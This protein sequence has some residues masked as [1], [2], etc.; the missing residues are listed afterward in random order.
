METAWE[1][2]E[3]AGIDP[4]SLRG[5]RTGVFTGVM[6]GD[7]AARLTA[8]P[9]EFEG[10]LLAGNTSS[11]VSGRLAYAYGLEGPAITVDT[12]CSS[13]LVSLHLAAQALRQGECDLAL[14]GGVT[15]MAAPSTFIE[16]SRQRGLAP[17]GRCKSFSTDADGTGWSE[18]VGLLLVE[19]ASDALARGH[20]ILA[21]LRGSAVNS[22]GASNGLTA[23]NGPSQDRVIRQALAAAGLRTSDVD[24]VEAHGTGTTLGDPIEA[25]ALLATY[26]QDRPAGQPLWLGSLKSN[27]GH[28]QAAAG[29]GGVIKMI[30]AL[31]HGLLP[32]TLHVDQPSTHVDWESGSVALLT[33]AQPWPAGERPRRAGVSSFGISGTNAHVILEEPPHQTPPNPTAPPGTSTPEQSTPEQSAGQGSATAGQQAVTAGQQAASAGAMLPLVLSGADERGLRAQADRLRQFVADRPELDLA[34]LGFSLATSRARLEHRAAVLGAD[35]AALL[36][37]L[38]ALARGE[39]AAGVITGTGAGRG[40][41]AFL[42]T[43]QGSQRVGMGRDL[44]QHD[45]VFA[46]ALDEVCAHLDGVLDRPLKTVLFA[47]EGSADSAILDQTAFTQAAVF[48]IEVALYRLAERAGLVPDYLLGHSV[49]EVAAAHVAGVLDLPDAC[50]LIAARGRAM[51]SARDNGAMAAIQASE[52]EVRESLTG[53]EAAVAIA[54]LNGPSATVI[55]GDDVAV[56]SIAA[57]WAA[58]GRRTARLPVSHA[59]HSPHMDDVL[60]AFRGILVE[61]TFHP[62]RRPIVSDVTGEL[63][64]AEQLCSPD[65]WLQHVRQPVRFLDGMRQL[66]TLGVTE[67]VELGPDGVLSAMARACLTGEPGMLAPMLRAGRP[68]TASVLA[69]LAASHVRGANLDWSLIFPGARRVPLP[70]YAFRRNRYWLDAPRGIGTAAAFGLGETGH[71]LLGATT[72]L[73]DGETTVLTGR[74]SPGTDH[75]LREHRV[76]DLDLLP[77]TAFLELALRAGEQVGCPRVAELTVTAPLRLPQRGAVALQVTVRAPDAAGLRPVT[78]HARP[79]DDESPWTRYASGALSPEPGSAERLAIWP[80]PRA[81]EVDLDGSYDRLAEHG[82]R[83]GPAF[84]GLHRLWRHDD[85]LYAEITLPTES[86]ADAG[87]FA[88]HPAL[89]DAALHALLPT[90][91]PSDPDE[92][93]EVLLPFSWSGVTVHTPGASAA[94]VRLSV[95]TAEGGTQMASLVLTD[96]TGAALAT[97]DELLLRPLSADLPPADVRAD[98]DGLYAVEWVRPP[99]GGTPAEPP[100]WVVLDDGLA[101]VADG[102]AEPV[103]GLGERPAGP[104]VPGDGGNP[105]DGSG[106]YRDLAGLT[107]ALDGGVPVPRMVLMPVPSTTGPAAELPDRAHETLRRMLA[108]SQE[109][110]A[111]ER[112]VDTRLVVVTRGAVTAADTTAADLAQAGV[113]GLLRAAQTEHP[114]R[115]VLL[116]LDDDPRSGHTLAAALASGEPQVAVRGGEIRVPRLARTPHSVPRPEPEPVPVPDWAG[117]TVLITGATGTLGGLLARHLVVAH[118]V[119][120][121]LLLS[122]RGPAAPGADELRAELAGLGATATIVAC[123][124][125]DRSALAAVLAELPAQVRLSAVVH[126]AGVLDDGVLAALTP[127]QLARVLRPKVDAAWHLHELTREHP[128]SAFVLYSSVAGLLGTA[129]QGNYCAAN[130][131]LD[132]L[133]QH[134]QAHGLPATSLAWG[135]WAEASSITSHL[136]EVDRQRMARVGLLPLAVDEAMPL[137]DLA[138]TTGAPVVAV[139]RLDPTAL[140]GPVDAHPAPLRSLVRRPARPTGAGTAAAPA[141]PTLAQRL[142]DLTVAERRETLTDL[143]RARVAM[144]LGHA[145]PDDVDPTRAFQELGFDSLTAI[146]LRNQLSTATGLR[147]PATLVFDY[148]SPAALAGYLLDQIVVERPGA[149]LLAE[150]DTLATLVRSTALDPDERASVSA[151]LR[152]LLNLCGDTDAGESVDTEP[153]D[154]LAA[155][156]DEE[157]FALVD[158]LD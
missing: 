42:F 124:V 77:G 141:G 72:E 94:R 60:D 91:A 50:R 97:V 30:Q 90:S 125:A 38:D 34:D 26:G 138:V 14:A 65:Y 41:T 121:L 64:T 99:S 70:T 134:R 149:E 71:P 10:F 24:A 56:D 157:L 47:P 135:L 32:R 62:P 147:L 88:V 74:L 5:S 85:D 114:D 137:F 120:D 33:S 52:D 18:G 48:A 43:G 69:V 158:D 140:R 76:L 83:Y 22:D 25:Q 54:A 104:A 100:D 108:F 51:Q 7:Y 75:W 13:S 136:A 155:A 39:D 21:V 37:G 12:A 106:P 95:S 63:A 79:D 98:Q 45:A 102:L 96:H 145:D 131:F 16:F 150:L 113:W 81:A 15:V 9:P 128:L 89:L 82:Y 53:F 143:V 156:S 19:R 122:R 126:T 115:F 31:R 2:F 46:T 119:R 116:D 66:Q 144:V 27:I 112:L 86:R 20:Q 92:K 36:R 118:G 1:V 154:D 133:A 151:R 148:P 130:T 73:A 11:V 17:D 110:L 35:R 28:A 129:G 117:G 87:L 109:W 29:V 61:L 67:F 153:V 58:K 107:V 93:A 6:Y 101:M 127:D 152:D 111:Q 8:A 23:P 146:E 59:F 55:S 78:I 49:G 139:T 80:P 68:E 105:P 3:H 57:G 132:A 142:A 40:R 84:R 4:G 123:D 44:Y 103:R